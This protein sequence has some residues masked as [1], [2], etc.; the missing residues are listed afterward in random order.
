VGS[1]VLATLRVERRRGL[2]FAGSVTLMGVSMLLFSLLGVFWIAWLSILVIGVASG[3][4]MTM[5]QMLI[6]DYVEEEYRGR[7]MSLFMMQISVMNL[8]T[9]AV[10]LYMDR[11][12]PQF[13]IGSLGV[14]LVAASLAYIALVPRLRRL[15]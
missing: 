9:F 5:S 6:Q 4:R 14:A 15:R 1:L 12:G 3:G 11:V 2:L 13:A 10:S 7:V 8:G